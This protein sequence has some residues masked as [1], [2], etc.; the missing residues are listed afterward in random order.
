MRHFIYKT[1]NSVNGKYY[2]GMHS[3]DVLDDGYIGS[4][5]RTTRRHF[6]DACGCVWRTESELRKAKVFQSPDRGFRSCRD[7]RRTRRLDRIIR[8]AKNESQKK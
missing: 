5:E 4:V 8:M 3:T 6:F 2:K 7:R 1:T